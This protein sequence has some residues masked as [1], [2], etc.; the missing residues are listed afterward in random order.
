MFSEK[1]YG[2]LMRSMVFGSVMSAGLA[3]YVI[4]T[5]IKDM[6]GSAGQMAMVQF[7]AQTSA[8]A[9]LPL[10]LLLRSV[11]PKKAAL[12]LFYT[13]RAF[14]TLL[15]AAVLFRF[16]PAAALGVYT[17]GTVLSG[18]GMG[19]ANCWLKSLVPADMRGAFFGK[20]NALG[21]II[22]AALTPL[23]GM[24]I[25]KRAEAG[26][27]VEYF[28]PALMFI[29]LFCG[30]LDLRCLSKTEC[31]RWGSEDFD[32]RRKA[33]SAIFSKDVLKAVFAPF[34]SNISAAWLA[35]FI[36]ILCYDMG[37]SSFETGIVSAVMSLGVAAG[38]MLG[39]RAADISPAN[40]RRIFV[41]FP[42]AN[43][44]LALMTALLTVFYFS[45]AL[46]AKPAAL[47]AGVFFCGMSFVSGIAQGAQ[48]KYSLE[49]VSGGSVSFS[50][51]IFLQSLLTLIILGA[52]V[53]LGSW[54]A[55]SA[56]MLGGIF[57]PGF[58]YTQ[59]IFAC[60]IV[61]GAASAVF[62]ARR[63]E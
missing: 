2:Y 28:Y 47:W 45:G 52:S 56:A 63:R 23:A 1:T 59:I 34:V 8:C 55:D 41:C 33:L 51:V 37:M 27:K 54:A 30:F 17:A 21:L 22:A 14:M 24:I 43:A 5:M 57:Y 61:S 6:G 36:V 26:F 7:L 3:P 10:A 12:T 35:P 20:R 11:N 32:E 4:I 58:H 25:D 60:S 18:S 31:P 9:S 46:S 15:P 19:P 42:A 13:G 39:G 62:L 40:I 44:V 29:P 49:A 38:M 16:S 53:K 48:T 50:A